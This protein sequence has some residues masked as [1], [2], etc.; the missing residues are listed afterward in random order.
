MEAQEGYSNVSMGI[1]A[2]DGLS[3]GLFMFGH[4]QSNAID[5]LNS[6][7]LKALTNIAGILESNLNNTNFDAGEGLTNQV[8]D[9]YSVDGNVQA[10]RDF[11]EDIERS[12]LLLRGASRTI[13]CRAAAVVT[14]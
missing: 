7:L 6:D 1:L 9:K 10:G 3:N 11:A 8:G 5:H 14:H 2:L 13:T 12:F 4:T